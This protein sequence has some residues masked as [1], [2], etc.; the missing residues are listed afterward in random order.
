M[1]TAPVSIV[2]GGLSGLAAALAVVRSGGRA[3]VYE[4]RAE[5]GARFHGDFQGLENWSQ[6]MDVLEEFQSF[7]LDVTF[8]HTPFREC[9]FFDPDG[10][11]RVCRSA[12]PLWYLVR[13]GTEP[14]TL[15]Q[16]LKRQAIAAGVQI[17]FEAS[18]D[19]LPEGGIVTY[20]PRRVDAIAVGYVFA[21]DMDDAAFGAVSDDLA[22]RG[23]AYLLV[24]RGRATVATCMF[25]DFHNDKRYLERTVRFFEAKTG[26]RLREARP[27]GGFGNMAAEPILRRGRILH[28][29]EAAGLQ[30]ALFGFGM[31]HALASGHLAGDA[32][33]TG[34][35]NRYE[36]AGRRRFA[37]ALRAGTVNRFLYERAGARGYR[38]MVERVCRARNPREWLRRH[39][40]HRWWMSLVYPLAKARIAKRQ[41]AAAHDCRADC[42]C[43]YCRCMRETTAGK[44]G[45]ESREAQVCAS[46]VSGT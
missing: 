11:E 12:Q 37:P 27:F 17:E 25:T 3:R 13:R 30:D 40:S 6:Q 36:V 16:A 19:Q 2:G 28:A 21:T 39:Y 44:A 5:T 33:A 18:R 24:C 32:I 42:D 4:R 41:R 45:V 34:E 1:A 22:P 7:G 9:V 8:E 43:T 26:V 31:R 20:G 29:G 35:L 23:Y 14:G 38:T 15:D 46:P 10:R